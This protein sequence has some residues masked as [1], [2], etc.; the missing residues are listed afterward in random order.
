MKFKMKHIKLG[1][2]LRIVRKAS[3]MRGVKEVPQPRSN[4]RI[5]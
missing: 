1:G 4:W 2:R 3:L 5:S